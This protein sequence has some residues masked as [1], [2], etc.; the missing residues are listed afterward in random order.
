[1]RAT[2]TMDA[3]VMAIIGMDIRFYEKR[4]MLAARSL[5]LDC[6]PM[7]TDKPLKRTHRHVHLSRRSSDVSWK[8]G[9]RAASVR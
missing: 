9:T 3:P 4:F 5:A 1:M 6:G 8:N 2:L 7:I